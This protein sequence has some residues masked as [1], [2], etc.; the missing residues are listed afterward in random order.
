MGTQSE[1]KDAVNWEVPAVGLNSSLREVV[2]KLVNNNVSAL[3]VK[4][5]DTVA[6]I[7]TD[8]DVLDF[9]S[10]Q[11][12]M[13]ETKVADVLTTCRLVTDDPTNKS[14]CVQLDKTESVENAIKVLSVAGTHNLLVSGGTDKEVGIASL[15]DLLKLFIS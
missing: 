8:M 11:E 7:I 12:D 9:I 1:I 15:H 10:D 4:T 2:Q 3:V 13:D 5:D 6:G 14:P